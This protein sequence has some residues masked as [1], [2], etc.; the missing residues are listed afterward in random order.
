MA[1]NFPE[2]LEN[3][4]F[5]YEELSNEIDD[6]A[7]RLEAIIH[8]KYAVEQ[9]LDSFTAEVQNDVDL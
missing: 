8:R 2:M 5:E 4:Q 7:H 3:L 6:L 9:I 1:T